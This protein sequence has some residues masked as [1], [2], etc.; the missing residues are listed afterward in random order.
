M[1]IISSFDGI[2]VS[3]T[4]CKAGELTKNGNVYTEESLSTIQH[5]NDNPINLGEAIAKNQHIIISSSGG[6]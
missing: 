5:I 4:V 2:V 3:T 6:N 1:T